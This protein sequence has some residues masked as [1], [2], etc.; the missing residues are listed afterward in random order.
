MTEQQDYIV[1]SKGDL[2]NLVRDVQ[3]NGILPPKKWITR[4]EAAAI[5]GLSLR[6]I[7]K[8]TA[9]GLYTI[10][11]GPGRT[12]RIYILRSDVEGLI[13]RNRRVKVPHRRKNARQL[14]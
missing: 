10:S 1:V 7:D 12:S 14:A 6:T 11:K 4:R 13:D 3:R 2:A 5:S 9:G 8:R